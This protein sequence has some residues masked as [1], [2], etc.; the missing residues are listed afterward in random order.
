MLIEKLAAMEIKVE[1][2]TELIGLEQDGGCIRAALKLPDGSEELCEAAY[3][4]ACDGASSTV[5]EQLR[6]GFPGGTYSGLFYVAGRGGAWTA[7][8]RRAAR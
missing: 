7:G 1:R 4:A 8:E 2:R 3:L 5:R 6:I